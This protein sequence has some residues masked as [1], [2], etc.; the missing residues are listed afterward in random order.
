MLGARC[1]WRRA[2]TRRA[3]GGGCRRAAARRAGKTRARQN[4]SWGKKPH[5]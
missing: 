3:H 4:A 5:L 2:P 1:C